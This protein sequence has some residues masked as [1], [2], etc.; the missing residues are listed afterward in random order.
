MIDGNEIDVFDIL[1]SSEVP[2][3]TRS[4]IKHIDQDIEQ[5]Q[6]IVDLKPVS[7]LKKTVKPDSN[8][9][10]QLKKRSPP[11]KA[12]K[13]VKKK[14]TNS[15]SFTLSKEELEKK[16][17]E[18]EKKEQLEMHP[19]MIK[20]MQDLKMMN[21]LESNIITDEKIQLL[22]EVFKVLAA[23]T[24]T[25]VKTVLQIARSEPNMPLNKLRLKLF[26][27]VIGKMIT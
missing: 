5:P 8:E 6:L 12:A 17:E 21:I 24:S 1:D 9:K 3:I 2:R 10:T 4:V 23:A 7:I 20:T 11:K 15:S 16:M 18:Q 14:K 19:K 26:H 25:N 13:N 27:S 22:S